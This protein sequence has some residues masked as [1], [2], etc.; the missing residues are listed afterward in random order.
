MCNFPCRNEH[1][2]LSWLARCYIMNNKA[3]LAWELYLRME[4]SDE[5]YQLLQLI[6]NDCYRMGAFYYAAKAFDVLERLDP[7]P[8]YL[9]GKKGACVGTFQ[10]VIAEK[11]K[12]REVLRDV[13]AMLRNSSNTNPQIEAISRTM[14]KWAKE[15]GIQV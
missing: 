14:V 6:A 8:E 7:N 11:E 10:A 2:Y 3:A 15:K 1:C 9:D 12:D 4:T 13:I 5:S